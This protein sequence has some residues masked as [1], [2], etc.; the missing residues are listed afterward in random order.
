M[1]SFFRNLISNFSLLITKDGHMDFAEGIRLR[2]V[3]PFVKGRLLD[4]GCG[5]N[6]LV[7]AYPGE[8]VGVD[9]FNWGGQPD[10][11]IARS[12][13]LPFENQTFDTV[14]FIACLNH[15]PYRVSALK[16]AYRVLKDDG[17]VLITMLG[18]LAGQLAHLAEGKDESK[19]GFQEGEL[20]GISDNMLNK[21]FD[22]SGF[23]LKKKKRI[24]PTAN[25][26]YFLEK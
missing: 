2:A 17:Q 12:D 4:V 11:V 15:I 18:P 21:I 8:G 9:V 13:N 7:A 1:P 3:L 14:T 6:N 20:P 19:R 22:E 23:I 10:R 24:W 5:Y 16:E 25:K 26:I